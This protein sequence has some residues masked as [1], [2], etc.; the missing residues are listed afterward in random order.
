[1]WYDVSEPPDK[2]DTVA[3]NVFDFITDSIE[4]P[5]RRPVVY[6]NGKVAS[7]INDLR[8]ELEKGEESLPKT[9]I[10]TIRK[11]IKE[12]Q[13]E[14]DKSRLTFHVR[15]YSPAVRESIETEVRELAEEQ[16]WD[17]ERTT[18][19]ITYRVF[20]KAIVS[21]TNA[22]GEKDEKPWTPENVNKF[23]KA[24]P[25]GALTEFTNDVIHVTVR[26]VEFHNSVDVTF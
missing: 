9:R 2:G 13:K 7:Q 26:A 23:M 5:E 3:F 10:A 20:A 17:E 18:E 15:G 25:N 12:L 24:A 14:L 8:A 6:M 16:G 11:D 1:M 4:Y 22:D 21:V 19:E